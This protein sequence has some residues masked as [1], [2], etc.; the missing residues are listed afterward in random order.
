[1]G[2]YL[3]TRDEIPDPAALRVECRLGDRL[4]AADHTRNYVWDVAHA[5]AH[6]SR[7]MTPAPR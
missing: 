4:V 2:P 6:I 5:L 7:T 3:V 1:M